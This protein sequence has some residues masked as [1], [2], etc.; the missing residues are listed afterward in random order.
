MAGSI[1]RAAAA[2]IVTSA[3]LAAHASAAQPQP[4]EVLFGDLFV[5]V[6][7]GKIYPDGKT[8]ADAV[9]RAAPQTILA[10]YHALHPESAAAL[11]RF[12]D[13]HFVLPAAPPAVAAAAPGETSL[14]GHIDRLWNELTRDTPTSP[15]YSSLLPLPKP[16]VVP[17]GRFQ[18]I[19]YWDSYFT[20]LGLEVSGRHDLVAD[21]VDDFAYL[22][23]RYGHVP[24]GTRSYYLSR[25]QPPFFFEM[26]GLLGGKSPAEAYAHYLPQLKREYAFWMAAAAGLEPGTARRRVV[27]MPDGAVLNRYFDDR[28]S[29]RDESYLEDTQLAGKSGRSAAAFYRD[30]RAAAESGWDFSSRWFAD[31]HSRA[32]IDTTEIVP[33]D[34]NSLMYGLERAIAAGCAHRGERRCAREYRQ[35][36]SARRTAIDRYLWDAAAGAYLDYDRAHRARVPRVSAA[37]LYPLFVGCASPGQA[38][39]VAATVRASLLKPGGIVTTGLTTGEQWDAPNGWA[40]LQWIGVAGLNRYGQRRLAESVACRWMSNVRRVYG[41]SGKLV[42][43]YDVTDL[44][45]AGGGGEYPAQDGF[46]WTNGVTRRLMAEYPADAAAERCPAP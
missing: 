5:A 9:P 1:V 28:D 4:P 42:E 37:T 11:K 10:E 29:P 3:V 2:A 38:G 32:T 12:V 18:E 27:A 13:A 36:A 45:H 21:M 17:G 16:Y 41:R 8:F 19:Y 34:L 46:G 24:N 25:S 44:G 35:R 31:A 7:T 15:P 6:Q 43:K 30:I 20:M 22:I 23:D 39:A 40:P 33:V 14:A 26:V